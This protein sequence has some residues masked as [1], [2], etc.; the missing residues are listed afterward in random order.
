MSGRLWVV[1]VVLAVLALGAGC[2][3]AWRSLVGGMS[4]G[5]L[6]SVAKTVAGLY[7]KVE[8]VDAE[9]LVQMR[10]SDRPPILLDVR[11]T[12][13][14]R[15]SH[16]EGAVRAETFEEA[17]VA[18]AGVPRDRPVVTYCSVGYR[19][20]KL[21][22]ELIEAGWTDV[23]NLEGSIFGWANEGRPVMRDGKVVDE[24][25]PYNERWGRLLK[26]ELHSAP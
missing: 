12:E 17:R 5:D 24:V 3:L 10:Q 1:L 4:P 19:S 16:I 18:L 15:V 9:E 8:Q 25:H 20:S 21:G 6:P 7:P 26:D 2:A 14:Y 22:Q 23:S 13:E 11:A